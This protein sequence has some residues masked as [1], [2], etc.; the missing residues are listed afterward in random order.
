MKTTV[1]IISLASATYR[2]TYQ[3]AQAKRLGFEPIWSNAIGINDISEDFFHRHAFQW[4]RALKKTEVACFMSHL[5]L[6]QTIAKSDQPA[7]VLEDDVVLGCDWTAQ[8]EVLAKTTNADFI[9]LEAWGKK[10]LGKSHIVENLM[11]QQLLLNS[12]GAAAYILWPSGAR[13]LITR[14]ERFG[15]AL[16]DA[17]INQTQGWRI[18]QL[19]PANSIQMNVAPDYGLTSIPNS[20]SLIARERYASATVPS[21]SVKYAMKWRRLKCELYKAWL[22]MS[23]LFTYKRAYIPYLH[24]NHEL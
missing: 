23:Y 11:L 19:I 24:H 22:R 12:A 16:A 7:V 15:V 17:F 21:Q 10:I 1:Y 6:W 2:R 5:Q 14:Y 20:E 4:Q 3:A 9:C 8:V 13:H 18:W